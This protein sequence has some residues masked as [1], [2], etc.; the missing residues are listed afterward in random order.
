MKVKLNKILRKGRGMFLAYDQGMEHGP[1]DFNDRNVDPVYIIDIARRGK[2][3]ALIFQK[4]IAEKYNSEIRKSGVPLIVKLNG[5]TSLVR[6]EPVSRQLCSVGEAVK[7]GAVAV[8]YT[9]YIGSEFESEMMAEF[10]RIQVEAHERG[11][12]VV[13]W[14]YPRGKFLRNFPREV[15]SQK[16]EVRDKNRELMAY[17]ARVG[18]EIGADIVKLQSNGDK[19]DLAWAVE[20]A[21]KCKIVVAGGKKKSEG[22]LLA[23]VRDAMSVG[24]VGV[25]VG[26]NVWQAEKPVDVAGKLR[27]IIWG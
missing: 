18:L 7:L 9:I 16:S 22:E 13:V 24:C 27:K 11:L 4:G 25:A 12:P 8:G 14:I 6:G 2:F 15:R 1:T 17:A 19:E 26:R 20:S 3:T 23:E 5:K 10:E 21:G